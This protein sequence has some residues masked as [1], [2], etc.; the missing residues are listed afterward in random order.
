M[1]VMALFSASFFAKYLHVDEDGPGQ[2]HLCYTDTFLVSFLFI[3]FLQKR[4]FTMFML[5][6]FQSLCAR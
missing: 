2:G 3:I 1:G 6:C 5:S 4:G